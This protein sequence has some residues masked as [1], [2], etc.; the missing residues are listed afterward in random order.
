MK[1]ISGFLKDII[2]ETIFPTQSLIIILIVILRIPNSQNA[3][4]I[5][6]L[7]S[8]F[9]PSHCSSAKNMKTQ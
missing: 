7:L 8:N 6:S 2:S 5:R 4:A 1:I 9:F 3:F